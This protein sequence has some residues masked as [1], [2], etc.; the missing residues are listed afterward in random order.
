MKKAIATIAI[1]YVAQ[2]GDH[3][4]EDYQRY[5]TKWISEHG[6]EYELNDVF[7]RFNIFKDNFDKIEAHN[8]ELSKHSFSMKLNE[9]AD[10]TADEFKA[11]FY[12]L[13]L[14]QAKIDGPAFRA[15]AA[16]KPSDAGV[17]WRTKNAVT[18][19][20]NQG[21]CG[22]CW[23]FSTTGSTEGRIAIDTG[24]LIALSEQQLVDCAG[25]EGNQGCNGGLMDDGFQYII[26]NKGL[27]SEADYPYKASKNFFCKASKCTNVPGSDISG[28]Q[29]VDKSETALA[30]AV[31]NQPVSI[32]IEAD[33]SSFQFYSGGVMSGACGT[34]LDHG[35]LAVGYGTDSGKDYWIVKNS[36]GASWGES[37]YIRL[38]RGID[39]CGIM[40]AASY[41]THK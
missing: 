23:A 3:T 18:P 40:Q 24:K 30:A 15:P 26:K 28:F 21:Q 7:P 5:F 14:N 34:N 36:W 39:Q 19:V 22:S 29:D 20:K 17:D 41:P 1:T 8:E 12:G 9:F 32:A 37:G 13:N 6:K 2:A 31:D 33:Q 27:C 16:Y 38:L 11:T 10:L 35:V 25:S 4:E